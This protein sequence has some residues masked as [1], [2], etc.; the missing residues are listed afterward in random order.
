MALALAAAHGRRRAP[1]MI[2]MR[3]ARSKKEVSLGQGTLTLRF[4]FIAREIL[5]WSRRML[6]FISFCALKNAK[7]SGSLSIT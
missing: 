4:F 7:D 5:P 1:R 6:L 3:A 2:M